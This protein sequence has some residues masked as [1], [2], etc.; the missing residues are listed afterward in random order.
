MLI[1]VCLGNF[2]LRFWNNEGFWSRNREKRKRESCFVMNVNDAK[3]LSDFY[4][5][6]SIHPFNDTIHNESIHFLCKSR[7]ESIQRF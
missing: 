7:S 4:A 2:F 3:E 1:E 5:S 6:E